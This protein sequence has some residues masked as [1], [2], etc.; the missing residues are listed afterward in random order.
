MKVLCYCLYSL[1]SVTVHNFSV[2][3]RVLAENVKHWNYHPS[4]E[5]GGH[6]KREIF[7]VLLILKVFFR[8]YGMKILALR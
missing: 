4:K 6:Q 2:Y 1:L 8:H 5:T 3:P 7:I